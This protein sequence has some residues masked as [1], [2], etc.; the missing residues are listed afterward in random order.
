M[1]NKILII[2]PH[3]DDESFGCLGT[4]LNHKELGDKF[5]FIWFTGGR[6]KKQSDT[7]RKV[8]TYFN[9]KEYRF[10]TTPCPID[11]SYS[12]WR[13]VSCKSKK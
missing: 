2:A 4:L 3:V 1:Q 8:L 10:N 13:N 9:T 6:N 5:A 11:G 12:D 7:Y